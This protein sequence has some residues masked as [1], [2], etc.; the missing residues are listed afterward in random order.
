MEELIERLLE[1]DEKDR[2]FLLIR[3]LTD[4]L[5]EREEHMDIYPTMRDF[6]PRYIE[7][8]NRSVK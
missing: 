8:V 7:E 4:M 6:M 3:D 1:I 5:K 2:K